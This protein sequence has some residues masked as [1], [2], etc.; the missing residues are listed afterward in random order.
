MTSSSER[1]YCHSAFSVRCREQ[2]L[3]GAEDEELE[4]EGESS[5]MKAYVGAGGRKASLAVIRE[6]HG[7]Q[8]KR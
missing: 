5:S 7:G 1:L 6:G 8:Q 3:T 4:E 2:L